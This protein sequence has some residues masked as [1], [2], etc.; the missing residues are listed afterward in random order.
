MSKLSQLAED[1]PELII[2]ENDFSE[3]RVKRILKKT[4]QQAAQQNRKPRKYY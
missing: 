1:R 2:N 3:S 4:P